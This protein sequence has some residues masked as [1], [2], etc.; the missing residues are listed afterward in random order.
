MINGLHFLT[1]TSLPDDDLAVDQLRV[2]KCMQR[3]PTFHQDIVG[4]IHHIIDAL[5]TLNRSINFLLPEYGLQCLDQ[6]F[7]TRSDFDPLNDSSCVTWA[8][9]HK[10]IIHFEQVVDVGA[11]F[12]DQGFRETCLQ[13]K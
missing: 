9:L 11:F 3:L 7:W 13:I 6:P 4:R 2:I 5:I 10:L 1:V 8:G 12:F